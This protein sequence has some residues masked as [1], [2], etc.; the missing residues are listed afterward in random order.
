[1][2]E[3]AA[4]NISGSVTYG[5]DNEPISFAEIRIDRLDEQKPLT[6]SRRAGNAYTDKNGMWSMDGIPDGDYV[7]TIGGHFSNAGSRSVSLPTTSFTVKVRGGAVTN[8]NSH[9]GRGALISGTLNVESGQLQDRDFLWMELI[10][11]DKPKAGQTESDK[12]EVLWGNGRQN[13]TVFFHDNILK[14]DPLP[15]GKY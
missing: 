7:V 15:P 10:N 8:L 6:Y 2:P 12:L 9:V 13:E 5:P 1:M 11:A 3:L 4:N 14:S